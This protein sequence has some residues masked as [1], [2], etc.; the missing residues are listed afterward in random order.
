MA[1]LEALSLAKLGSR[2][3]RAEL[4]RLQFARILTGGKDSF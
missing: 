4:E 3:Q 1:V 2:E